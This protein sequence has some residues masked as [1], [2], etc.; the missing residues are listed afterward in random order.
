MGD[1][2]AW[3]CR[4]GRLCIHPSTAHHLSGSPNVG[5]GEGHLWKGDVENDCLIKTPELNNRLLLQFSLGV[6]KNHVYHPEYAKRTLTSMS[7][8]I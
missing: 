3:T 6:G 1:I 2:F 5:G 7:V 8:T 4:S